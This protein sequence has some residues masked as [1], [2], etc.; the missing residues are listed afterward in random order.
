MLQCVERA[1]AAAPS[2]IVYIDLDRITTLDIRNTMRK[3]SLM[4][5]ILVFLW[6]PF[7]TSA[8]EDFSGIDAFLKATLKGEDKLSVEARGDLNGD[9]LED[10][11]GVI[12]RQKSGSSPTTQLYVLLRLRE[13]GYRVAEKS[14]EAPIAGAG[15]CW[16]ESLEISRSSLYIQNNAKT[17]TTMEAATHQFKLYQGKWRLVGLRIYYDDHGSNAPRTTETDMNLLT[18]SVIEK[19]QKGENRPTTYKR[20][21]KFTVSLLKDFDFFN[22][23]GTE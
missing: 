22:G 9:G 4:L 11:A 21:K 1:D 20:H 3:L 19:K 8:Q 2:L 13:G 6:S 12:E 14:K 10:W 18:G 23:F 7:T 17:A 16:V 15:C 5:S